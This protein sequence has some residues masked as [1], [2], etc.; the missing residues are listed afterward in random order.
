MRLR[1]LTSLLE[2]VRGLRCDTQSSLE[3]GATVRLRVAT[4]G[5]GACLFG[6][7]GV[8]VDCKNVTVRYLYIHV[9]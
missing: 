1:S 8:E 5:T 3:E 6:D 9:A 2:A 7:H 4:S